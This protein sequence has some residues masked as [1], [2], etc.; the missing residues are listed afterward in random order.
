MR[1]HHVLRSGDVRIVDTLKTPLTDASGKV[2]GLVAE[3]RDVTGREQTL[4]ALRRSEELLREAQ[5][6]ARI[7]NWTHDMTTEQL[8]WSDEVYRIFEVERGT[9]SHRS[10]RYWGW[11]TR[12]TSRQSALPTRKPSR[13]MPRRC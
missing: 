13:H 3:S 11:C 1:E 7:G 4:D 2:Y 9:L 5:T 8:T 6:L 12:T 10:R